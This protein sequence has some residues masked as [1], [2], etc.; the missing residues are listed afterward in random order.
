MNLTVLLL[1]IGLAVFFILTVLFVILYFRERSVSIDP[2]KC[3]KVMSNYSVIPN[4]DP[5]SVKTLYQCD[6]S[7]TANGIPGASVC[8]F[9]SPAYST[10]NAVIEACN[11]YPN[12]ICGGFYYNSAEKLFRI[13]NTDYTITQSPTDNVSFGDVYLL[14]V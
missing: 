9:I 11:S 6:S 8:Q 10:L 3:P 7:G 5:A 14:Q 12:K 4:V 1:S 13:I 2:E